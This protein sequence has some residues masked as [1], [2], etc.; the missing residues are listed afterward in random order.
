MAS[1]ALRQLRKH[2]QGQEVLKGI[3]LDIAEGATI[4]M[5]EAG[6]KYAHLFWLMMWI[7]LGCAAIAMLASPWLRR[8]MRAAD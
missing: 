5:A 8:A 7:G 3:S 1:I 2:F 4:N 6:A